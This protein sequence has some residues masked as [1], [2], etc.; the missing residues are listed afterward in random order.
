VKLRE[1]ICS[2]TGVK[3]RRRGMCSSLIAERGYIE[4]SFFVV[5]RNHRRHAVR[6]KFEVRGDF[7]TLCPKTR[8]I[9]LLS[10]VLCAGLS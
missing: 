5:L 10:I 7:E 1:V 9:K 8:P 2:C 4:S 6:L 3:R